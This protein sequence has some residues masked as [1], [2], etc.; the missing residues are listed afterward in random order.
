MPKS[1]KHKSILLEQIYKIYVAQIQEAQIQ[2]VIIS[3]CS[4]LSTRGC[5]VL[6]CSQ[7]FK[8]HKNN[9]VQNPSF[10]Y[11]LLEKWE[12]DAELLKHANIQRN[13]GHKAKTE[14]V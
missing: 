4:R 6:Y 3:C 13:T 5:I 11:I 8:L 9:T 12:I 7:F 1:S 10:L 2:A 14:F